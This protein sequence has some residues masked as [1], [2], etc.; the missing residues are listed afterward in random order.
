MG[1]YIFMYM[2]INKLDD[3]WFVMLNKNWVYVDIIRENGS[4]YRK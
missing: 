1:I 2:V 4:V 3:E